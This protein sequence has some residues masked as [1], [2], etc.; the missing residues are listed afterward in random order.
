MFWII[1][2]LWFQFKY[3]TSALE[4]KWPKFFRNI[5]TISK[6]QKAEFIIINNIKQEK[7]FRNGYIGTVHR[8]QFFFI[9]VCWF[10]SSNWAFDFKI[11]L[12]TISEQHNSCMQK[13]MNVFVCQALGNESKWKLKNNAIFP[14]LSLAH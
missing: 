12:C 14:S 11:I 6:V 10:I 7:S 1:C 4:S 9:L 3:F 13:F 8:F 5:N 2:C